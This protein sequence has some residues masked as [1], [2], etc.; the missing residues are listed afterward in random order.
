MR[1]LPCVLTI[2]VFAAFIACGGPG[3]SGGGNVT[4]VSISVSPSSP[5]IQTGTMQQFT[6]TGSF[7]DNTTKDLTSSATWSSS[8]TSVASISS[9]GVATA[10]AVG[11]T[12]INAA[13]GTVTGST[14]LTVSASAPP[15]ATTADVLTYHNDNAR[16]GQNLR[17]T[18]L[19]PANVNATNFG[20]LFVISVDGKVDAQ[21][22]YVSN[23]AIPGNGTH[24]VLVV[25]TEHDSVYAFDA[26]TAAKLWQVSMLQSGE[27][28]SEA[29]FGCDQVSPEIG[30]TATPVIDRNAGP[31]G[32][33]Y[34]VAMSKNGSGT[35]FQRLHGLNLATGAE[36]FSGPQDVHAT[37][38]GSGDNSSG[39]SEIFDPGAYKERPGLLLL[40]GIVYTAWSSHCDV[41]PYTGWIIGYDQNTLAQVNVLNIVPNGS[42]ASFWNSGAGLAADTNGNIFQLAANGTFETTLNSNGFPSQGDFGNA[43]LKISTANNRLTVADY[44]ALFNTVSESNSDTDLGSGGAIVLPDFTDSSG[45]VR[46]LAVGAGKDG[47]I[48]V[49]DRDNMGKFNPNSNNIYQ[50]LSSAIGSEFGIPAYFNNTVFYGGVSDKLKAFTIT[51]AKLSSSPASQSANTFPYPGTSPSISANGTSNGIVWAT[52]N[53]TTAALH[54]YD[55]RNLNELYNSNQAANGRD[56][57]G[58][59]NKFIVPT[60]A[61]GKVYVGTTN[62]VGVFGLLH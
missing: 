38:P 30:V 26:D 2:A 50:Q 7:S 51:N 54:A 60:I 55:A 19:T 20:K 5:T 40:N 16:T 13:S 18:T 28:T 58:T 43:F 27:V 42:E 48:Y 47:N 39:G 8:T 29:R 10:I 11:S 23:V 17:E 34:V 61:N 22:L 33:I 1:K 45:A 35:Y 4:L 53:A 14:T 31:N 57:F 41:R 3:S 46:R 59:G 25:A 36:Q 44:S 24:N 37:F 12:T 62:G 21:P 6:A 9:S 15:P 52:D 32:T 56:H 49:V